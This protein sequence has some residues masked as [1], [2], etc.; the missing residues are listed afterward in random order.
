MD[1]L[2]VDIVRTYS[3]LTQFYTVYAV[4][5]PSPSGRGPGRGD[6]KT[7]FYFETPFP[8]PSPGGL[9]LVQNYINKNRTLLKK[10][11]QIK[12]G[13]EKRGQNQ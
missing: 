13:N 5:F 8:N 10:A 1:R 12:R 4:L 11:D 3:L 6:K 9:S 7:K 2:N